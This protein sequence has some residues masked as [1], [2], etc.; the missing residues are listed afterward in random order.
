MR[1]HLTRRGVE[2]SQ[3]DFSLLDE[4]LRRF[5]EARKCRGLPNFSPHYHEQS[6]Y[7]DS[8]HNPITTPFPSHQ[9][10]PLQGDL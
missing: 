4:A 2:L 3:E 9:Y 7:E 8:G 10:L 6:Y 5:E 1:V